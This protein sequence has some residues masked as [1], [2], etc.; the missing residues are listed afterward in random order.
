LNKKLIASGFAG[1]ALAASLAA[2]T[3]SSSNG[4]S[5]E[6]TQQQADTTTLVNNQSVPGFNYSQM[7]QNL[8]EIETAQANGAQST[9]FFFTANGTVPLS[10][11]PSIGVP[12]PNTASLSNPHQIIWGQNNAGPGVVDQMDPNG[13]YAPTTSDGT[14]VICIDNQGKGVIHYWEGPVYTVFAPAVWDDATHSIKV[15]GASSTE[16]SI[17]NPKTK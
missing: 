6:S 1:L 7:R 17:K 14:Y 8:I 5:A 13:V 15:I 12:I 10:S 9:S 4:N 16:V 11:C 3:G 2:C